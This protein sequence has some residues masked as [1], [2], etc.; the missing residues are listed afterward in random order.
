MALILPVFTTIVLGCVDFGRFLYY[1]V[2]VVNAARAGAAYGIMNNYT[3]STKS[4]WTTN[5]DATGQAEMTGM[6]GLVSSN[7]NVSVT[8]AID[9]TTGY[10][11]ITSTAT[12]KFQTVTPWPFIP[13]TV[14]MGQTV[15]MRAIR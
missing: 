9:Q 13:N 11:T 12:Y 3:S 15:Q 14:T 7:F 1:H 2:G 5:A 8:S 4:T 10:N 6:T